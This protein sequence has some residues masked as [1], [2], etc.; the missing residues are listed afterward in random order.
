MRDTIRD[1]VDDLR[2][3][4]VSRDALAQ[5]PLEHHLD[6]GSASTIRIG[7]ASLRKPAA[8]PRTQI[9][10]RIRDGKRLISVDA[11]GLTAPSRRARGRSPSG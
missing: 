11:G 9:L 4:G 6:K 10:S 3:R 8:Q 5:L 1:G 7:E 2:E